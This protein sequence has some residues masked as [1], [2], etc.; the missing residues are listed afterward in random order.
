MVPA[1]PRTPDR[2][3]S[4]NNETAEEEMESV[5]FRAIKDEKAGWKDVSDWCNHLF[6]LSFIQF[7]VVLSKTAFHLC[8]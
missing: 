1:I 2:R 4:N 6:S 8:Y 5:Q 3:L 7:M